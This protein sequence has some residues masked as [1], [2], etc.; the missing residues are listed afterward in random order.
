MLS[1]LRFLA[2]PF[3]LIMIL[4]IFIVGYLALE[5]LKSAGATKNIKGKMKS[6]QSYRSS[7][8]QN[9]EKAL[10]KKSVFE[11]NATLNRYIEKLD[12]SKSNL[13]VNVQNIRLL[14]ARAG[15]SDLKKVKRTV[16]AICVL[17]FIMGPGAWFLMKFYLG[18][19]LSF[20]KSI[21]VIAGGGAFGYYYPI[22]NLKS[23]ADKRK[24]ELSLYFPD[25]L[26]LLQ[27][28]VE[29][30]MSV[31]QSLIKITDEIAESS[32]VTAEQLAITSAELGHLLDQKTAYNNLAIRTGLSQ[33][34]SLASV[35]IQSALY[36]TPLVQGL[37]ALST[38]QREI[39]ISDIERKAAALP[40]KL[41]VPLMLFIMPVLF[42]VIMAPAMINLKEIM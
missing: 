35:L 33:Y 8:V 13:F 1:L 3:N 21:G 25:L 29:S 7:L 36:G 9:N 27:V 32:P 19:E 40:A 41:T 17:P 11:R 23:L 42:V 6:V 24:K 12:L 15:F 26:D 31:E 14:A 38:E 34:K 16:F 37:R 10:A 30:G 39:Q 28:C 2:D 20:M 18:M 5:Y 4:G 22:L